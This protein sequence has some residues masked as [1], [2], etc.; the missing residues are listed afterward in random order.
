MGFILNK[1]DSNEVYGLK[2]FYADAIDDVASLPTD[3]IPGSTCLVKEG[4][5]LYVLTTEYNWEPFE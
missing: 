2:E 5:T 3:C 4:P 1:Q